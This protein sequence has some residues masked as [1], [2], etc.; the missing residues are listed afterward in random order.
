LPRFKKVGSR[1]G[2]PL[3]TCNL[4][5]MDSI[6]GNKTL[7]FLLNNN[8]REESLFLML[9]WELLVSGSSSSFA[10]VRRDLRSQSGGEIRIM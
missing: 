6:G 3:K 5:G 4:G 2:V 1:R 9:G 7:V 10:P 8:P